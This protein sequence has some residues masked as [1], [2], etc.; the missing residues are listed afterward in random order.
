MGTSRSSVPRECANVTSILFAF[1]L[2]LTLS[3]K[4]QPSDGLPF[5]G[6]KATGLRWVLK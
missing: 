5:A 1:N 3:I 6:R 2:H 4:P